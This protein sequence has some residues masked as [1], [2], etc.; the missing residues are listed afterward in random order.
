MLSN[1][2][3]FFGLVNYMKDVIPH[4]AHYRSI[5]SQ[6]LT[7]NP[8]SWSSSQ[9]TNI[10]KLKELSTNL[11]T[12]Q[13]PTK[14]RRRILQI[15]ASDKYWGAVLLDESKSKAVCGYQSGKLKNLELHYHSTF[16]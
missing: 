4:I 1:F 12:L 5:L 13:I 9:F 2:N 6:L 7:K 8:F 15:D 3:N 10:K 16:K 11:P 14:K